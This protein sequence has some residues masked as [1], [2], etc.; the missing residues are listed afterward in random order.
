MPYTNKASRYILWRWNR[1]LHVSNSYKSGKIKCLSKLKR[2]RQL[3]AQ[4]RFLSTPNL[5]WKQRCSCGQRSTSSNSA[6][7]FSVSFPPSDCPLQHPNYCC[8]AHFT[9]SHG[10]IPQA[11]I[12]SVFSLVKWFTVQVWA[13]GLQHWFMLWRQSVSVLLTMVYTQYIIAPHRAW[14]L[15]SRSVMSDSATLW[16]AACQAFLSFTISQSLLKL[17]SIK[18]VMPSNHLILCRPL[19]LLPSIFPSIRV[20]SNELALCIRWPKYW[21]FI[22]SPSN[23]YSGLI[24]FKI[25]WFDLLA[26]QGT[27]KSLLQHHSWKASIL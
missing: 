12:S 25:D 21:S 3:W 10:N 18:S 13:V 22:I 19:L 1:S 23:E 11:S 24:S 16:T 4:F 7:H 15:F 2:A 8:L 26:V 5:S 17:M 9:L 14:L 20:F 27:V 6:S